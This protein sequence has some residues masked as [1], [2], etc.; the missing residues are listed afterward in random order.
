MADQPLPRMLLESFRTLD[1]QTTAALVDRGESDLSPGHASALLL[2]DRSGTRLTELALRAQVTK[3]A[4]MQVVDDLESMG[5]V[6]RVPDPTDARAK[7]VK[8]TAKGLRQRADAR[9][10]ISAVETRARRTL[11]A[12]RYDALRETLEILT[13]S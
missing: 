2:V 5:S 12:R 8:L 4:M 6:R 10:A 13:A 1:E 11:G 7:V 9:K 3:Q